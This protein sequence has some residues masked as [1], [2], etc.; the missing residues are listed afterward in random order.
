MSD[1][2]QV[3]SLG[4]KDYPIAS[5]PADVQNLL[6]IY[7]KWDNELKNAKVEVFKLE[8]ALKGISLEIEIRLKQHEST[9]Q[10]P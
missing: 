8:A 9:P 1:D 6:A 5:L 4:G 2:T 3:L 7:G 10:V